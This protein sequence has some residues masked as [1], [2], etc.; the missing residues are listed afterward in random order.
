MDRHALDK[1]L[2]VVF[3]RVRQKIVEGASP[4]LTSMASMEELIYAELNRSKAQVLQAWCSQAQDD[5]ARPVC[6]HCGGPMRHKGIRPK[7]VICEGGQVDLAR[8]RWWC[9]ACKASFSP[10]GRHGDGGGLS[11]DREGGSGGDRG[12]G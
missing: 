1:D 3:D 8:T 5:S 2:Q 12:S 7:T 4:S 9:D 10:S 6:P 11:G